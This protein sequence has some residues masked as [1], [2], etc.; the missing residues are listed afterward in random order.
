[1]AGQEGGA[2][3][4]LP[5]PPDLSERQIALSPDPPARA[6]ARAGPARARL[7][8]AGAAAT[9]RAAGLNVNLAPGTR[10]PTCGR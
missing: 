9:M 5:G 1:M 7:A 10:T 4:R 3:R 8:G 6:R 2:V